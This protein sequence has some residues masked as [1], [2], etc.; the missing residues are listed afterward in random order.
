MTRVPIL[1]AQHIVKEL[2][3]GEGKIIA[4][5]DVSLSLYPGRVHASY[6]T[7]RERKDDASFDPRMHSDA[8]IGIA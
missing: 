5:N 6:G 3:E 8:D 4:L 7:V 2:G 1:E